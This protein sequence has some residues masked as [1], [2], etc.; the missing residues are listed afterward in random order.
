[1]KRGWSGG[2]YWFV[3]LG[4]AALAWASTP[5]AAAPPVRQVSE[6]I[7]R[8]IDAALKQQGIEPAPRAEEVELHRRLYLDLLGRIPTPEELQSFLE[9]K[10]DAKVEAL[11]ERLLVH[12]EMPL[13]WR[14]VIDRWLNESLLERPAGGDEFLDWLAAELARNRGWDALAR[15]L[16][17]PPLEPAE[18]RAASYFLAS[19]LSGGDRQEQLDRVTSAVASG[20]FGVQLQ[21]AKCHDHPYV[22]EWQQDHYYGLTAFLG[23]T[24]TAKIENATVL[25]EKAE[26]EVTF[27]TNSK[28][29]RTAKLLFLDGHVIEE[30]APPEDRNKWYSKGEKGAP[31]APY[32]SRRQALVE[33]AIAPERPAFKRSIANRVWR[34]LMGR[35]LV[36]PVDQIHSEN[37]AS[38]PELL[39]LLAEDSAASG[40][41]LRRLMAAILHS[42]AYQRSSRWVSEERPPAEN[43][44]TAIIKPLSPHQL[45]VSLAQATGQLD[46][47]SA[48]LEREKEKRK[49]DRVD[50][51][52]VRAAFE[53][54]R[55]YGSFLERFRNEG[56][57]FQANASQ[58]LFLTYNNATQA[59]LRPNPGSLTARMVETNN[60]GEAARLAWL[61]VLSREPSAEELELAG[62]A[63]GDTE[64]LDPTLCGDLVWALFTSAEFRF[65]H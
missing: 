27:V 38:H 60:A 65:N 57:E 5:L 8:T 15:D 7:D 35:G 17:L 19:R 10:S 18:S 2:K 39:E 46:A 12:E 36:E 33:Y 20:L 34:E 16:L 1:M 3:I 9:D 23:R 4:T 30:P 26:G 25:S 61:S 47:L 24:Q 45:A 37:K 62:A 52:A 49:L 51:F 56:S 13:H 28:Q 32:F 22:V 55:D 41:D 14:R 31:D 6:Q 63:L 48:K 11:I 29:E 42:R 40:F 58:A 64:K 50:T 43:Y 53:R 21:C 59:M 54:E 44:T